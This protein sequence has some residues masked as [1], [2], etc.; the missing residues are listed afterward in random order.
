MLS[1]ADTSPRALAVLDVEGIQLVCLLYLNEDSIAHA[2]YLI[3]RLKRRMPTVP[4]LI[5]FLS[6]PAD[7]NTRTKMQAATNADLSSTSLVDVLDQISSAAL[8][9][10]ESARTERTQKSAANHTAF[11]DLTE[12]P[13]VG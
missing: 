2:R 4:V 13:Q 9:K 6:L 3:R 10:E 1:W 8:L 12:I 11:H 5:A 7:E